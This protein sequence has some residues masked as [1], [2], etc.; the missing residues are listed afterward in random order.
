MRG[1]RRDRLGV[2]GVRRQLQRRRSSTGG[3]VADATCGAKLGA[4]AHRFVLVLLVVV[5]C[6]GTS[7][8]AGVRAGAR[9][10]PRRLIAQ[11]ELQRFVVL[12]ATYTYRSA[13]QWSGSPESA[14]ARPSVAR[15][16]REGFVTA[17]SNRL[18]A[19]HG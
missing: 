8:N 12:P 5:G 16:H 10:D 3:L 13:E 17:W 11:G 15:L 4:V 14:V 2:D 9:A 1:S 18:R 19:W 6:A 7:A